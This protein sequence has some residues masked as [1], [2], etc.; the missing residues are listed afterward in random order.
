MENKLSF[1]AEVTK[2]SKPGDHFM[3]SGVDGQELGGGYDY[4][5]V[6]V[7]LHQ[8]Q[9]LHIDGRRYPIHFRKVLV[10]FVCLSICLHTCSLQ[11]LQQVE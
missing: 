11:P 3:L 2:V 7:P 1:S 9:S 8:K 5:I 10:R 4:V 6:A